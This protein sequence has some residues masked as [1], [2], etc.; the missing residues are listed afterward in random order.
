M[1]CVFPMPPNRECAGCIKRRHATIGMLVRRYHES[2]VYYIHGDGKDLNLSGE[3]F[4]RAVMERTIGQSD[5]HIGVDVDRLLRMHT[6]ADKD[7]NTRLREQL[8]Q[9]RVKYNKL[10]ADGFRRAGQALRSW[11]NE[12]SVPSKYR[13]EGV[14]EAANLLDPPD[15][16]ADRKDSINTKSEGNR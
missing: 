9:E 5:V 7:E 14:M 15:P 8:H 6:G 13:R 12:R 16:A 2:G 11:C 1:A 10:V 4:Y 3:E